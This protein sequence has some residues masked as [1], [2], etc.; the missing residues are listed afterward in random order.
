M[1]NVHNVLICAPGSALLQLEAA[2]LEWADGMSFPPF[3][4]VDVHAGGDKSMECV[5][6]VGAFNYLDLAT[7]MLFLARRR[8]KFPELMSGIQMAECGQHAEHFTLHNL[9]EGTW[10]SYDV[11]IPT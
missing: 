7:L 3:Q 8:W 4:R 1:S 2:L 10:R 5:M 6:L 11:T 9:Y